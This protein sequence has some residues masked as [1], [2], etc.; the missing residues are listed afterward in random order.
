VQA[1]EQ[2][3]PSL[4]GRTRSMDDCARNGYPMRA[5]VMPIISVSDWETLDGQFLGDLLSR[6]PLSRITLG[7]MCSYPQAMRLIEQ[8]LG[9][10]NSLSAHVDRRHGVSD[11]QRR[12]PRELREKIYGHLIKVIQQV[13]RKLEISTCLEEHDT[14]DAL[15]MQANLG[16]CNCVL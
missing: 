5:A 2:N 13:H 4:E 11:G 14:F 8:K 12:F 16:R 15:R 7:S 9:R 6:I 10:N 3:A 1:F